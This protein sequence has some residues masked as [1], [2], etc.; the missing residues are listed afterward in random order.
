MEIHIICGCPL[1]LHPENIH[2]D[3]HRM[4]CHATETNACGTV[5]LTEIS[6]S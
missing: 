3:F 5:L 1:F 6:V 4:L 2:N